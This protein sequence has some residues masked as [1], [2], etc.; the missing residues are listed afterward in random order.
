MLLLPLP[1]DVTEL[2]APIVSVRWDV[3]MYSAPYLNGVLQDLVDPRTPVVIVDLTEAP[4]IDCAGLAVLIRARNRSR[5]VGSELW[6]VAPRQ[7]L[8]DVTGLGLTFTM[9]GTRDEALE[10]QAI[11]QGVR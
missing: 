1:P 8:F 2:G 5:A 7:R 4:F 10:W 3:D 11:S 6:I 9:F